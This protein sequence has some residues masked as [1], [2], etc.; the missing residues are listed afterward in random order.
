M[1][2]ESAHVDA[3]LLHST[4]ITDSTFDVSE[5]NND[6]LSTERP[7]RVMKYARAH[8]F[9]GRS[10]LAR[11]LTLGVFTRLELLL[12]RG[13]KNRATLDTIRRCRRDAE[14][15]LTGNEA[16]LLHSLAQAQSSL[17]GAMAEL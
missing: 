8:R 7:T 6:N 13:H 5:G 11:R 4:T 10:R 16:F 15:L 2:T 12:L 9:V 1:T 14:S 17:K 3:E